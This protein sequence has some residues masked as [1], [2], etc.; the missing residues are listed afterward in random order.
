MTPD[1]FAFKCSTRRGLVDLSGCGPTETGND[2][3]QLSIVSGRE[4]HCDDP[5]AGSNADH[6]VGSL[7]VRDNR[8]ELA[9]GLRD[10]ERLHSH[11]SRSAGDAESL[12][13]KIIQS[14]RMRAKG[15]SQSILTAV[16]LQQERATSGCGRIA[17]EHNGRLP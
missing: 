10:R 6:C 11:H 4:H 5:T 14:V 13:R 17:S 8:R 7:N 3:G 15:L 16:L 9:L 2:F 12:A 1:H